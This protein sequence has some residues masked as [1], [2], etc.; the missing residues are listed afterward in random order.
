MMVRMGRKRKMG[1]GKGSCKTRGMGDSRMLG[2]S[3]LTR[4]RGQGGAQN[5]GGQLPNQGQGP[6]K[7]WGGSCLIKGMGGTEPER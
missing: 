4:G 3:C 1:M 2:G 7:C 5:V 6:T